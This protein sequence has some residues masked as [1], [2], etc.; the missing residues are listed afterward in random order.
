MSIQEH[1]NVVILLDPKTYRCSIC[2][3]TGTP[4]PP[5]PPCPGPTGD[6]YHEPH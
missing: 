6:P 4:D 3:Q 2:G 5:P 1:S